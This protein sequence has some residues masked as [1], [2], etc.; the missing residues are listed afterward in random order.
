M[1]LYETATKEIFMVKNS[2]QQF[3]E[4]VD[5]F[6]YKPN[7]ISPLTN[8]TFFLGAGFSVSAQPTTSSNLYPA[9]IKLVHEKITGI[10]LETDN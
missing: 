4:L 6:S 2:P 10:R 5:A 7:T 1:S 3:R 9:V 8:V